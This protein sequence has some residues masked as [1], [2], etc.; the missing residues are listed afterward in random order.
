MT[1]RSF[2]RLMCLWP[3]LYLVQLVVQPLFDA[4]DRAMQWMAIAIAVAIFV[5]LYT[6]AETRP[7]RIRTWSPLAATLVG[8]ALFPFN[9]AAGV[10]FVFAAALAGNHLP[11]QAATRWLVGLTT[12]LGGVAI[13]SP[14]AFPWRIFAFA[15][16]LLFVWIVG[17]AC[18]EGAERRR[19]AA[20]LRAEN[21]RIEHLAT[22]TE[23]ERIARD[24]HD[25]LGHTLT[26]IL[27]RAQLVQRLAGADPAAAAA[28][29]ADV[30]R[31]AREALAQVRATVAGWRQVDL[32]EELV[33][34]RATLAAAGVELVCARDPGL[35]LRPAAAAS[36]SPPR[37]IVRAPAPA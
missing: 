20:A 23:R 7:G 13:L 26:G 32:D 34:A 21:V 31:I 17:L 16:A 33:A 29:A 2:R 36:T 12:L 3:L 15:P 35:M 4:T 11:R 37:C 19:R 9:A 6:I 28:E 5:P 27:V 24:L 8:L 25:L 18:L 22:L 10:F 30:E 1:S 14:I